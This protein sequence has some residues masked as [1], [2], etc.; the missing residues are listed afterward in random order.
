MDPLS[1]K[2]KIINE[3]GLHARSAGKIAAIVKDSTA[4]VWLIRAGEKADASSVI[5]MLTLAC[6]KG[7]EI[8]IKI[9]DAADSGTLD[10]LVALIE[11]GFG[12]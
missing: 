11:Q 6:A 7:T 9:D 8:T 10:A 2:V 5:D 4:K 12:E 3:L 1:R